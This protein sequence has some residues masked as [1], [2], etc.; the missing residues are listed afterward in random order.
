[1]WLITDTV[2]LDEHDPALLPFEEKQLEEYLDSLLD[3]I[4]SCNTIRDA[5]ELVNKLAQF[6]SNLAKAWFQ[7]EVN[8]PPRC[9]ELVRQA[10]RLDVCKEQY[11]IYNQI[12]KQLFCVGHDVIKVQEKVLFVNETTALYVCG[13][14]KIQIQMTKHP[15]YVILDT[16]TI[17]SWLPPYEDKYLSDW[18]KGL[19]QKRISNCL[20]KKGIVFGWI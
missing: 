14:R 3:D 17:K 20:D 9:K 16:D 11:M 5:D 12:K 7:Y 19:I 8:I 13:K 15:D 2:W 4:A 18:K 1:M 10:D 6:Q